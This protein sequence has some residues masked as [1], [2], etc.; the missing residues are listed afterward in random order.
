MGTQVQV[1]VWSPEAKAVAAG[2]ERAFAEISRVEDLMSEWKADSAISRVNREAAKRAIKIGPDLYKVLARGISMGEAS[3]GAFD[4]SWAAL[5]GVWDFQSRPPALPNSAELARAVAL[6]D[7][8]R[9]HLDRENST[10][11]LGQP[12]MVLGLGGIA[13]GYAVD[14]AAAVLESSGF[15]NFVVSAGGDVLTRGTQGGQPWMVGIQHPRAKP[16]TLLARVASQNEA[17][18]TSGDYERFMMIDGTRYH[19]IL[20]VQTGQPAR[21]VMSVSVLAKNAMDADALCTAAFVMGPQKGL[22]FLEARP[23]V[24]GLIVDAEGYTHM[25]F[26]AKTRITVI[27]PIRRSK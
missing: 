25:T 18:V 26:G 23:G 20:N 11:R 6:V 19:H 2:A 8:R 13:K 15:H 7:Y 14:R 21:G 16:G 3:G 12:G 22:A 27:A 1:L 10:V 4:I 9:V 17:V 24:E 5:R